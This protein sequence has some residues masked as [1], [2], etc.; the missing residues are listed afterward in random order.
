MKEISIIKDIVL[1]THDFKYKFFMLDIDMSKFEKLD[2]KYFSQNSFNLFSFNTKDHFGESTDFKENVKNLLKECDLKATEKMRFVT[3]PAIIGYVFNPI[4]VLILFENNKPS[5][6]LAEVHNYNGGR[7][8]YNVKLETNDNKHYKGKSLKDMYVSPFFKRTGEYSF[9][10]TYTSNNFSIGIN[11]YED[12]K[13]VLT[14][15]FVGKSLVFSE[16]NIL[17]LFL[18]HTLLTFWVVTRTIWQSLKL[19]LKGLKWNGPEAIDQ[20]RRA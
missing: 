5:F 14:S 19:K 4:S 7:I 6:M 8:I 11:L 18:R 9:D 16:T 2:N 20:I 15:T 12:E 3:L 10:L 1:K 13:K 17:S